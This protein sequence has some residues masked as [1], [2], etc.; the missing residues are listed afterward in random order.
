[1]KHLLV[2]KRL[3]RNVPWTPGRD[4]WWHE[5]IERESAECPALPVDADRPCCI[6]YTS[7]TT[8]KP[9]GVVLTQGGLQM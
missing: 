8:G 9:K 7:G 6:T 2:L 3:D 4:L 1:V 5:A